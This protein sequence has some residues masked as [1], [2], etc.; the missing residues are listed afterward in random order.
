MITCEK[1]R[2]CENCQ[3]VKPPRTIPNELI[4]RCS[5]FINDEREVR[6]VYMEQRNKIHP[7]TYIIFDSLLMDGRKLY[8]TTFDLK[9]Y[10]DMSRFVI[11][12]TFIYRTE[13]RWRF[14]AATFEN[15]DTLIY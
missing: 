6:K 14:S 12:D 9:N 15:L 8:D 10:L 7:N 3:E 4:V 11:N 13:I 2:S 1:E 5:V